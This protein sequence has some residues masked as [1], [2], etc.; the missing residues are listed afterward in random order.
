MKPKCF[1]TE[2]PIRINGTLC[3]AKSKA[4]SRDTAAQF[5]RSSR[6]VRAGFLRVDLGRYCIV[7]VGLDHG[8]RLRT[9]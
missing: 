3:A 1:L 8:F 7:P 6:L 2:P 9:R 4:V 5:L